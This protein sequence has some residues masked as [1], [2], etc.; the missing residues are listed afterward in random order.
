[1][2]SMRHVLYPTDFSEP[3]ASALP[4]AVRVAREH[5]ADLHALHALVLHAADE[6]QADRL[7]PTLEDA[8]RDIE[9]WAEERMASHLGEH[10]VPEVPLHEARVR[11]F[12]A[13]PVILEYAEEHDIDLIVM[14][15]HGRRGLRHLL[16]GSVAEEVV[17]RARCPVVT[18]RESP[19]LDGRRWPTR[20]VVPL[21]F[22]QNADVALAYARE[23]GGETGAT[24][25]ILHVVEPAAVPDPYVMGG[26]GLTLD[27][28]ATRE[29]VTESLE[30]RAAEALG[31]SV[32]ATVHVEMG[33]PAAEIAA[34]AEAR[35]ADLILMASHGH[36][37]LDR[38][39]L[40]SV[41]EGVVRRASPP[42]MIVKPFGHQLV[43]G[44]TSS[45]A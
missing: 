3:A 36:S 8:Y 9:S 39:L 21:D 14:G 5:G 38:V 28:E 20:V 22:S 16:L 29:R 35:S 45:D 7:F 11:G 1:M 10:H 27:V 24:V 31:E 42:L 44:I 15:T 40:G 2:L 34:F 17:R 6:A 23:L 13:A 30:R 26:P 4:L 41:A 18:V 33:R 37:G 43:E 25:D 32:T 12:A 19:A